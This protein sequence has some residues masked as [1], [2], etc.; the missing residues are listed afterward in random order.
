M[1]PGPPNFS[2]IVEL[3]P[4][5]FTFALIKPWV[6]PDV[7]AGVWKMIHDGGLVCHTLVASVMDAQQVR[8][9]YYE[10]V[11]KPFYSRNEA[12]LMSGPSIKVLLIGPGAQPL[13]RQFLMPAIRDRFGLS[14]P[15]P[16]EMHLNLVHGSDSPSSALREVAVLWPFPGRWA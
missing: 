14:H 12:Y 13:W 3:P 1:N 6:K 5:D 7:V 4:G 15:S 16:D 8:R 10:H 2:K 9:L 11:G